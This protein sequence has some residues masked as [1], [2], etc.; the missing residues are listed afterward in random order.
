MKVLVDTCVWSKVFRYKS[1]DLEIT[2]KIKEL[3][4][5][6]TVVMIGPIR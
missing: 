5:N 3:I 1:S 4:K 2:D 6:G